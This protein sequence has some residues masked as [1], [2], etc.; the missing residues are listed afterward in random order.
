MNIKPIFNNTEQITLNDYMNKCGIDDIKTYL[1]AQYLEPLEHYDNIQNAA[2]MIIDGINANKH[3]YLLLDEDF[4][5]LASTSIQYI[6]LKRCRPNLNVTV[7]IHETPKSHGLQDKLVM[8]KLVDL[9]CGVEN[10]NTDIGILWIADASSNEVEEH[11]RLKEFGWEIICTDHHEKLLDNPYALVVS[12]LFSENVVNKQLSGA[13]VTF[14]LCQMVDRINN[15]AHS[16]DLISFVH[17]SNISDSRDFIDPEQNTFRYWGLQNIHSNLLPFISE[18]NY[19]KGLDNRSFSFG[20]ISRMNAVI[21]VG[22]IQEKQILF[23]ALACGQRVDEAIS[24]CK[25]C[26]TEQDKL[27]DSILE[28]NLSTDL[29]SNVKIFKVDTPNSL[30]GLIANRLQ[31]QY[32]QP[33]FVVYDNGESVSGS[34]RSPIEIRDICNNSTLFNYAAGHSTAFGISWQKDREQDIY[35]W[36]DSLT[37]PQPHIDVL[38]SWTT[39]SMPKYLFSE[40]GANTELIG[41]I[42]GQGIPEPLVHIHDIRF[43]PSDVKIIGKDKRTLKLEKDGIAFMWFK[44][45]NADKELLTTG[46]EKKLELVGTININEYRGCKTN[47]IKVDKFE[48]SDYTLNLSDIF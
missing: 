39:K 34:V 17:I 16:K 37:L 19:G 44:V 1:S 13:G 8:D 27:R 24:I 33:V 5:G 22:T 23:L 43:K 45:T 14:K 36:I 11:K 9:S 38:G 21:R 7:L 40:F 29:E 6:Y 35:S 10:V 28:N 2:Q 4:D 47:Q 32:N 41:G 25:K 31:S 48:V 42:Y 46:G 18:F 30:N 12:N 3:F 26:K 15:T 20:M